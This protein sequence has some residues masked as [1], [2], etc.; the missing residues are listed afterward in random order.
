MKISKDLE[1]LIPFVD[2]VSHLVPLYRLQSIKGYKQQ[3]NKGVA[4]YGGTHTADGES[5]VIT[6]H[7][8]AYVKSKKRH[9]PEAKGLIIDTL[10]HEL[11]HLVHWEHSWEHFNLQV[12]ILHAWVNIVREKDMKLWPN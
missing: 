1:W 11:A 10:A 9:E 2:E 6:L 8:H 5:F 12:R 3:W 4:S 7:T